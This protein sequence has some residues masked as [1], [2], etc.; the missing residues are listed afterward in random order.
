MWSRGLY[1][2][3]IK[4]VSALTVHALITL[5]CSLTVS[6]ENLLTMLSLYIGV[7]LDIEGAFD[8]ITSILVEDLYRLGIPIKENS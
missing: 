5:L 2:P 7:F 8:N 3:A 4:L 1:F 6:R